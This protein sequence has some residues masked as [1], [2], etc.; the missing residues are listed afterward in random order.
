M[1]IEKSGSHN[2]KEAEKYP[3]HH[4]A[5]EGDCFWTKF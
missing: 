5:G 4:I 3:P 1:Y 2:I